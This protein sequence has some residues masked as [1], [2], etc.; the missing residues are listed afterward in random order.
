LHD[1]GGL[2]GAPRRGL[3]AVLVVLDNDGGGVFSFLPQAELGEHFE[4]LFGT[5]HGI[6]LLD[7]CAAY[8]IPARRTTA[9]DEV[10]P[11][12]LDAIDAGGVRVV[13]VPTNRADNVRRH[14]QVWAAVADAVA[15]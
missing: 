12:V 15:G 10:A 4:A 7:V 1:A 11:A 9:A 13:I 6:D 2:L 3:D 5:P 8:G 14:R